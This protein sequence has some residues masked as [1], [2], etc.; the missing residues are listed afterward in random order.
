MCSEDEGSATGQNLQATSRMISKRKHRLQKDRALQD[1]LQSDNDSTFTYATKLVVICL[2]R[3]RTLMHMHAMKFLYT[4][5]SS[6][7]LGNV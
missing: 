6:I 3:D 7:A 4:P 2:C 5:P 1:T